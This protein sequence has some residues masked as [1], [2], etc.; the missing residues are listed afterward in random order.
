MTVA[1]AHRLTLTVGR[2][3]ATVKLRGRLSPSHPGRMVVVQMSRGSSWRT[4][5]KVKTTKH[6]TF[7]VKKKLTARGKYKFRARTIADKEH[8]VGL[9]PVAY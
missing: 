3:G 6:S 9:S 8:L 4:L 1:V 7:A 5:A 2:L